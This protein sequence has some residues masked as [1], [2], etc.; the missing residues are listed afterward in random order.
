VAKPEWGTKRICQSCSAPFYDLRRDPIVCPKCAAVF[1]PEAIL[2][3]RKL[4]GAEPPAEPVKK[5][6]EDPEDI[7]DAEDDDE[8]PAA[9]NDDTVLEDASDLGDEEVI[10]VIETSNDKDET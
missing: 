5:K 9:G 6:I 7:L 2:K 3:S 8:V 1:D 4:K 10:E